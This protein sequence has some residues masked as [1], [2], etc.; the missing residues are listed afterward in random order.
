MKEISRETI[1]CN[2]SSEVTGIK[3]TLINSK[4][5]L[6]FGVTLELIERFENIAKRIKQI[7]LLGNVSTLYLEDGED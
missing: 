6:P 3:E 5:E 4:V 2:L 1:L 7:I